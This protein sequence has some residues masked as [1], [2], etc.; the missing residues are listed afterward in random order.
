[1]CCRQSSLG[2]QP[3]V[4]ALCDSW[5]IA[6]GFFHNVIVN[7]NNEIVTWGSNSKGQLGTIYKCGA[8]MAKASSVLFID[9]G[10]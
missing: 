3:I 4:P 7:M 9:V 5:Q 8:V 6:A 1:M 2:Q 10:Q